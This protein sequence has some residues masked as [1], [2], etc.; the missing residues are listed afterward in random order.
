M[1]SVNVNRRAWARNPGRAVLPSF[2]LRGRQ[3]DQAGANTRNTNGTHI[4]YVRTAGADLSMHKWHRPNA[5]RRLGSSVALSA[6]VSQ[7]FSR[8]ALPADRRNGFTR[9]PDQ[10]LKLCGAAGPLT[11]SML[12]QASSDLGAARGRR[13]TSRPAPL[14][15]SRP[16]LGSRRR[17]AKLVETDDEVPLEATIGRHISLPWS[18]T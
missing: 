12:P 1:N 3:N 16:P 17:G 8:T 10:G 6:A 7:T 11:V 4:A 5:P 14:R 2:D 13:R 15:R 18:I 9:V